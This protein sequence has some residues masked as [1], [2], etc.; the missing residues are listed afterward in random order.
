MD[1]PEWAFRYLTDLATE[2][3]T[4]LEGW[5]Q[6]TPNVEGEALLKGLA[7]S[8]AQEG[9]FF[10][11]LRMPSL[12]K[13][14]DCKA[15]LYHT[16]QQLVKFHSSMSSLGGI[17]ATEV[18]MKDFDTNRPLEETAASPRPQQVEGG[19]IAARLARLAGPGPRVE[20][21][22]LGFLDV[23]ASADATFITE[24]LEAALLGAA[25]R[26][27][28]L[29][30][31]VDNGP[32]IF[33]L[34]TLVVD[35]LSRAAERCG[36]LAT[37]WAISSYCKVVLAPGVQQS[38][39]ALKQRWNDM[40]DP[41]KVPKEV[42]RLQETLQELVVFLDAF[43]LAQYMVPACDELRELQVLIQKKLRELQSQNSDDE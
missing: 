27:Q 3:L 21:Q 7:M 33:S 32:E 35:L 38:A 2:H 34:A 39:K 43:P 10:L 31:N 12:A 4:D 26:S 42:G 41:L 5:L 37:T 40:E 13:D 8:L 25:W 23:W 20:E 36:C 17:E 9:R 18:L 15:F 1:K 24:K 30:V 11:R 22:A 28:P 29:D 16:L 14:A 6:V 19:L